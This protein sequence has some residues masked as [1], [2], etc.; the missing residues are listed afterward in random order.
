MDIKRRKERYIIT[1]DEA[2]QIEGLIE[3]LAMAVWEILRDKREDG[4]P[5]DD[6]DDDDDRFSFVEKFEKDARNAAIDIPF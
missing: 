2:Y 4:P 1:E 5:I 3:L 6:D